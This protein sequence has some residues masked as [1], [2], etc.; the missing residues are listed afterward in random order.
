[1]LK[2]KPFSCV[3]HNTK[4]VSGAS[5]YQL[6]KSKN[7]PTN[8]LSIRQLTSLFFS[9]NLEENYSEAGYC[10][11]SNNDIHTRLIT[12]IQFLTSRSQCLFIILKP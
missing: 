6:V 8:H 7:F 10:N 4:D 5:V 3:K 9:P 1:M 11:M 12:F 2:T